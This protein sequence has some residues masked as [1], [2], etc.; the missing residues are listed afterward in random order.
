MN[1]RQPW[2]SEKVVKALVGSSVSNTL[3][4]SSSK[5][6]LGFRW[7]SK[8]TKVRKWGAKYTLLHC[9][10]TWRAAQEGP[11]SFCELSKWMGYRTGSS[12]AVEWGVHRGIDVD[13]V[14]SAI[15]SIMNL[16]PACVCTI[17]EVVMDL[18]LWHEGAYYK[19][20]FIPKPLSELEM[21]MILGH[22]WHNISYE[23]EF[24]WDWRSRIELE[25]TV[26]LTSPLAS[27][28]PPNILD[29]LWP[30][31]WVCHGHFPKCLIG[32]PF[33]FATVWKPLV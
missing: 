12:K 23:Y 25:G 30:L 11:A 27:P 29:V 2:M 21:S 28:P 8:K 13:S 14:S 7:R 24:H 9:L 16:T 5:V 6:A 22:F 4:A 15:D 18:C 31:Q 3:S 20:D 26:S 33:I 32:F 1:I 19:P 17:W 10:K